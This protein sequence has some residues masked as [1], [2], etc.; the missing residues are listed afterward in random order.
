MHSQRVQVSAIACSEQ[1]KEE[2]PEPF[3]D[4]TWTEQHAEEQLYQARWH[5]RERESAFAQQKFPS[6]TYFLLLHI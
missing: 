5:H 6:I 4:G 2:G 1:E 3:C